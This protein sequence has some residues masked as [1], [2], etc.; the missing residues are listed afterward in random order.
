LALKN[1]GNVA[2]ELDN[3]ASDGLRRARADKAAAEGSG[4]NGGAE[5]GDV[6]YTHENSS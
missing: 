4:K 5:N 2:L 1:G 6:A 3:F